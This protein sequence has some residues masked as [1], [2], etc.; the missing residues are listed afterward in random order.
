MYSLKYKVTTSTC[1]SEGRLKLY[2]ALQMMQDCSEMW[3]DSEPE[4]KD[5]FLQQNMAQLLA[6]RQ[7]EII[8]VPEYKEELT[9]TTSVY[10]MKPMFGF[11]N[12][13]IYDAQGNPCYKTWSMGAFVDK[14]AGKLKRV[15]DATIHMGA[16]VDKVAGKL[17]RVDD[18]TIQ[19]MKLEPQLEMNYKDRRI[20]LPKTEG[21]V[22]E[23]IKVL[24]A[25]IDYNKHLNNANYVR[26]AMELLPED[27]V[28]RGLRVEYR[29]A[30]KLGNS[31]TPIIYK[32]ADGIIISLSIGSEVSAII[33]FNK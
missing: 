22:L 18:A 10:G 31:L 12:T 21:E 17:K 25:D 8:R 2:S 3:I 24:R 6:T 23:P 5:Y 1:D 11:R 33:E 15:D 13:F 26:M 9:V 28:V 16:F 7:V 27:F 30:A 14:V 19:S 32:I 20:I 4:V 29:V